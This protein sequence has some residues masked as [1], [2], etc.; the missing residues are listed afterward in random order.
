MKFKYEHLDF[1]TKINYYLE[2]FL[3]PY[4]YCQNKDKEEDHLFIK[5]LFPSKSLFLSFSD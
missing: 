4:I 3:I 1:F 2:Y 5:L